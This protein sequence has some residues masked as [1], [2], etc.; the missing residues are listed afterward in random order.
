MLTEGNRGSACPFRQANIVYCM[1][2]CVS[3]TGK[4]K[5]SGNLFSILCINLTNGFQCVSLS[6][7]GDVNVWSD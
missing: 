1:G 5:F 2:P 7:L 4:P 3:K 6:I